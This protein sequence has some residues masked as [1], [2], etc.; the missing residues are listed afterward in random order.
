[1]QK[2]LTSIALLWLLASCAS[3]GDVSH[4]QGQKLSTLIEQ[5]GKPNTFLRLD[6]G[7]KIVE[8]DSS[9]N[10]HLTANVCSLT[11]FIDRTNRI[12]GANAQGNGTNCFG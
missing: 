4:W 2:A 8:Y 10:T 7:N 5:Y 6:D 1:M 11:F 3:N 9:S 12:K